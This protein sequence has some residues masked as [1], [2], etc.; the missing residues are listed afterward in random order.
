[1]HR[2][3]KDAHSKETRGEF[4][5]GN[6]Q[7]LG[8]HHVGFTVPNLHETRRFFLEVLGFQ[9][10]GEKPEYPAVFVSDGT[11]MLTLWQASEPERAIPFDRK[12]NVGLH[13]I[14]LRVRDG[15]A[16]EGLHERLR[17]S[18]GVEVEFCPE[19]LG[20]GPTQHMMC[21]IPGGIR[22]EFIAAG[23]AA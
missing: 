21:T 14:A 19:P 18:A 6:A 10:V 2:V 5:M 7:T 4:D 3:A 11:V 9:Q 20:A 23:A 13:H 16:L 12:H 15:A 17:D 1:M 22:V 8:V